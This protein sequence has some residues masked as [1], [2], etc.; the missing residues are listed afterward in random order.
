MRL[1]LVLTRVLQT[2]WF[3]LRRPDTRDA[4]ALLVAAAV[5]Y[6]VAYTYDLAPKLFQLGI[7]YAEWELDDAIFVLFVMS[8]AMMVYAIR[9]CRDLSKEIK[10][11]ISA[12]LEARKLARHDPLT[13]LPNRRFFEEQLQQYLTTVSATHQ[14][15]VLM[16]DLDGFKTVN[17]TYGHA[18]GDKALSEFALRVS[19]VLRA[20]AFLARIGGDEFAIIK[21]KIDSL[22]DPTNLARRIAATVAE[23]FV[24]ENV[25]AEFGVGIGIAIAPNDGVHADELA[26][27][28]D[29]ALCGAKSAGRSYV[30]FFEPEMDTHVERRIQ[31]ERELRSAIASNV[32]VPHYQ[33]LVSL[34][35]NHII[36]FEA[37]ARWESKALGQVAPD[38]FIRIAEE[39]GLINA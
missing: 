6:V 8:I 31:I 7:D 34:D 25:S 4:V 3:D 19:K 24:I 16:L 11:R 21:P 13:G 2:R 20:G 22:E 12:E 28:P 18:V 10:S 27:H 32:I 37:L 14:V 36:G 29:R 23:P 17:D 1:P 15:A 38:V 30:R 9:R 26:R 5:A 33:P 35:G 39:T